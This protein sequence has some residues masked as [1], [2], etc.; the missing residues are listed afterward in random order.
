MPTTQVVPRTVPEGT[1]PLIA[2]EGTAYDCGQHYGQI[3][4]ERYPGYRRY[5]DMVPSWLSLSVEAQ[6]LFE[7]RAPFVLDIY[8][9]LNRAIAKWRSAATSPSAARTHS[10]E[11]TSFGV[12]ASLTLDGHPISGQNKDTIVDSA[13]L[14][15]VLRMRIKGGPCILVLAYPGEVL[16]YGLWST[17]MSLF[18][19]NIYCRPRSGPGLPMEQ[20]GL[21]A[22]AGTSIDEATDIAL[23]HGISTTANCLIS[24]AAGRSVNVESHAG[25]VSLVPARE[26]IATHANNPLGEKTAPHEDYKNALEKAN[27]R[28]RMDHLWRLLDAERGRLTAGKAMMLLADH[29]RYPYG[30]CR[31]LIADMPGYCTTAAVVAEPTRGRLYVTRGNP[32]SSWPV[33][34]TI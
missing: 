26:G 25:E 29:T 30:V 6:K 12:A 3:V 31:H 24:D 10:E 5:L 9:G 19:N 22:L 1:V 15:V 8:R 2:V 7:Q 18:R 11:C 34:Y 21:L 33:C 17:G 20:W 4:L 27:S 28:F 23:K 32:C 16:G 13:L 14:Y